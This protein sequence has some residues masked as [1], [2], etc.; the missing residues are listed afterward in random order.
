MNYTNNSSARESFRIAKEMFYK[1]F[2]NDFNGNAQ[3]CMKF[4]NSLKLSQY[5]L[6]AEVTLTATAN[7]FTFA[8]TQNTQNTTGVTFPTENRL[9]MQ[10]SLCAS[11]YGI[12]V[13]QPSSNTAINWNLNTYG[14]TQDFAAADAAALDSTFYSHGNLSVRVNNDVVM[15]YRG[16]FNNWYKP[17]TQQ[18]G[19]LGAA[20]P[21]SQ[22]RGAE[23]GFVTLEP[24]LVIIGSKG[25]VAQINLPGNLAS[26]A[27]FE[28]A[29]IIFRGVLAQNST[30][31]S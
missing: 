19:A 23:D 28:R 3:A 22:L 25:Y 16:I 7:Q 10:D 17:Q 2:L 9:T 14:N 12:F 1:A 24:N 27:A 31:V 6:R 13:G 5:E 15:P 29:I 21:K 11:E 26:A 20:S 8:L 4:V 30:S 18:T